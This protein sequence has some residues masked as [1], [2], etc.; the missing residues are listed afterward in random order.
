M[1]QRDRKQRLTR[2]RRGDDQELG[3][4]DARG[5]QPHDRDHAG[6]EAPAQDRVRDRQAPNLGHHLRTLH[7]RDVADGKEDRRLGQAVI[8]HVQQPGEVRER[9][10]HPEREGDDAHVLDRRVGEHPLDVVPPV[11]H[12]RR[13]QH[14]DQT[15]RDHQR[16]GRQRS[17][18]GGHHHLEAEHARTARRSD[19]NPDSTA[20]MG[21]G[22]SACASGSQ[23]CSGARPTFVP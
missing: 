5:R 7:L 10:T 18:V 17:G 9:P 15:Q 16:S 19:S 1:R 3:H 2:K 14:G 8:G 22:P 23:A 12:E 20:E 4:E 6:D 11:Q 21:V 13:E